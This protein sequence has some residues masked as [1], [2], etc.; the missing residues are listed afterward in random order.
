MHF[1]TCL[2][3]VV[4]VQI[5]KKFETCQVTLDCVYINGHNTFDKLHLITNKVNITSMLNISITHPKPEHPLTCLG[6][7]VAPGSC[8]VRCIEVSLLV[9][10]VVVLAIYRGN[11]T[12]A[13]AVKQVKWPFQDLRGLAESDYNFLLAD[14]T[15]YYDTFRVSSC[16][17]GAFSQS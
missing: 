7:W 12:A 2:L 4:W 17:K 8:L 14:G 11:L 9:I 6:E 3:S 1:I 15:F 16:F 10:T 13:L 5:W